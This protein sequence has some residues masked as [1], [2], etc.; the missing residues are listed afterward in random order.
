MFTQ[1]Y[2]HKTRV[3]YDWHMREALRVM[4]SGGHFRKPVGAELKEFL[5]WDDWKVLGLLANGEGGEHGKR[6]AE[7]NH[8]RKIY[9]TPEVCNEQDL[10]DLETAKGKLGDLL[11]AEVAAKKSWYKPS[12]P[13]IPVYSRVRTPHV[14]PLSKYSK[15]IAGMKENNQFLL[16]V[17]AVAKK[18]A[19]ERMV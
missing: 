9:H 11:L 15:V 4:L 19:M 1:V 10:K 8:Y 6:I 18:E 16:Y 17:D 5:K 3:A 13:D 12:D 14:Q 2:F 7:R